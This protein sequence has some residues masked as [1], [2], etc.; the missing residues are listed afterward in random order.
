MAPQSRSRGRLCG[1]R[2]RPALTPPPRVA[3][4][5]AANRETLTPALTPPP[6]TSPRHHT[7]TQ[8][9]DTARV[10]NRADL[11]RRLCGRSS[12]SSQRGVIFRTSLIK[13][14]L[15]A[16]LPERRRHRST[17]PNRDSTNQPHFRGMCQGSVSG[18]GIGARCQ[19][20]CQGNYSQPVKRSPNRDELP[21]L[22]P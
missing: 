3:H 1:V 19:G 12:V 18:T 11:S 20:M 22:P 5:R 21:R 14:T 13:N 7:P 8:A 17:T 6:D 16:T 9:P 4:Q 10:S 15:D 2:G